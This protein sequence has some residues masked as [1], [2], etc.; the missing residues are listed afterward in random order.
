L[1]LKKPDIIPP[2][3]PVFK[4]IDVKKDGIK[5]DW[6]GS[7]SSD[8][9]SHNLFRKY[10][11]DT[12]WIKLKD[13]KYNKKNQ[14]ISYFD[15]MVEPGKT[16]VYKVEAIDESN[17]HSKPAFSIEV[18]AVKSAVG[19]PVTGLQKTIDDQNGL[20]K[21]SWKKPETDVRLFMIYRKTSNE[22][23]SLYETIPGEKNSF[24]DKGIKVGNKYYYRVKALYKDNS[25]SAFSEELYCNF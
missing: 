10:K 11:S 7:S 23:Y 2:S 14:Q 6:I 24:A 13:F 12:A 4:N 25:I 17:N 20:I 9:A 15:K 19:E 16:V 22:S 18:N 1:E 21:I 3:S 5:V 8:I